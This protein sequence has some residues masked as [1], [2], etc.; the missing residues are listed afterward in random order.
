MAISVKNC[1]FSP[2]HAFCAPADGVPLGIWYRHKGSK[3]RMMGLPEGQKN[4]KVGLAIQTQYQSVTSNKTD[5]QTSFDS[6]D[7]A[8]V[9]PHAGKNC[10]L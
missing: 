10:P 1:Q 6:G 8:Y 4:F 9:W 2:P 7:H 3:T 5:G